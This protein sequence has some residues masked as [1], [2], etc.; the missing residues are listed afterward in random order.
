MI[1]IAC[2]T[3]KYIIC[4]FITNIHVL[5]I[6]MFYNKF[7]GLQIT[8]CFWIIFGRE[9]NFKHATFA[10]INYLSRL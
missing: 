7:I 5:S 3:Y 10:R 6:H 4:M 8:G 1:K 2:R 9:E